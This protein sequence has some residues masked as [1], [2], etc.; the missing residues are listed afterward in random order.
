MAGPWQYDPNATGSAQESGMTGG[1]GV[2]SWVSNFGAMGGTTGLLNVEK[3]HQGKVTRSVNS[4]VAVTTLLGAGAAAA[5]GA[6]AFSA[7]AGPGGAIAG[8]VLG[9]VSGAITGGLAAYDGQKA[10]AALTQVHDLLLVVLRHEPGN[11]EAAE[12]EE[13]V[14]YCLGKNAVKR[15]K[16]IA[17]ASIV[18]QPMTALYKAG[19]AIY[20]TAQ[21]TKG[22]NRKK[23]A[24]QLLKLA[25][26]NSP[27][28]VQARKVVE[29]IIMKD[30][31]RIASD[32]VADAMKSG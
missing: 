17:N 18:G 9:T 10:I 11:V 4:R 26:Q 24:E 31:D 25:K 22:V 15:N 8:A 14:R 32:A 30:Y 12:L 2:A 20:K 7:A 21:G 23:N 16:G 1:G 13:C 3:D 29:I 5:S 19:K 6:A 27:I 28:G